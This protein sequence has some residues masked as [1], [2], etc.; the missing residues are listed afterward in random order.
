MP[1]SP[2]SSSSATTARS[3]SSG[4]TTPSFQEGPLPRLS[5]AG[6][7]ALALPPLRGTAG[8]R[9]TLVHHRRAADERHGRPRKWRGERRAALVARAAAAR[10]F[11]SSWYRAGAAAGAGAAGRGAVGR[12]GLSSFEA[13]C[14]EELHIRKATA[15]KLSRRSGLSRSPRAGRARG[16][17]DPLRRP[18]RWWRSS[19]RPRSAA[20]ST[21]RSYRSIRDSIWDPDRPGRGAPGAHRAFPSPERSSRT[22][23]AELGQ[24]RHHA[25]R[26]AEELRASRGVPRR[27]SPGRRP[28]GRVESLPSRR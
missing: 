27:P 5:L 12:L 7:P 25:R 20:S 9:R 14:T 24:L 18:S 22:D 28:R 23:A 6:A 2:S 10:R 8:Q 16:A 26:L 13:Y 11:K 4:W 19:P 17:R 15:L 1:A 3:R 21:P